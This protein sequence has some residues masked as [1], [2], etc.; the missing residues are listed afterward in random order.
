MV[1]ATR[2]FPGI[3][4]GLVEEIGCILN[5]LGLL[6]QH[7]RL[8]HIADRPDKKDH[9]FPAFTRSMVCRVVLNSHAMALILIP[10]LIRAITVLCCSSLSTEGRP[11]RFMLLLP[12]QYQS[13]CAL[14]ANLVQIQPHQR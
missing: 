1:F 11:N 3:V 5:S 13:A 12:P 14:A 7:V 4:R 10:A 8:W 2:Y 6:A 9:Y